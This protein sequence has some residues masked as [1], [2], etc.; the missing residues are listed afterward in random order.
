MFEDSDE[1]SAE[2]EL[3]KEENTGETEAEADVELPTKKRS[4]ARAPAPKTRG[5]ICE[6]VG[7]RELFP[8]EIDE[9]RGFVS[10]DLWEERVGYL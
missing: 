7:I 6:S 8:M 1:S 3:E 5:L 9:G 2:S 10:I 4:A